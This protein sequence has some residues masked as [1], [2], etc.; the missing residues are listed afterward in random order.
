MLKIQILLGLRLINLWDSSARSFKNNTQIMENNS[1]L[2]MRQGSCLRNS[3][4]QRI[5]LV[6]QWTSLGNLTLFTSIQLQE[7]SFTSAMKCVL[8]TF[9]C[10][11][12]WKFSTSSTARANQV[13]TTM[14]PTTSLN[15][16]G[17]KSHPGSPI[18]KWKLTK[19]F[20]NSLT[21]FTLS[22]TKP[23]PR[24]TTWWYTA[25]LELIGLEP[26]EYLMWW[27]RLS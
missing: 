10:S 3:I 13:K 4:Y 9:N 15:T 1:I 23:W 6:I 11:P 12:S 16:W 5:L 17:S 18:P 27:K 14:S 25:L 20:S 2:M 19:V 24:V 7:L 22:S 26:L 8:K 21:Q